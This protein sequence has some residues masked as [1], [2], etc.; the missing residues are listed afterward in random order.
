VTFFKGTFLGSAFTNATTHF[1]R[2]ERDEEATE[3]RT[4]DLKNTV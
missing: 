1:V 3:I 2:F 4:A